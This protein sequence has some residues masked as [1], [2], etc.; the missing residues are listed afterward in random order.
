MLANFVEYWSNPENTPD[1]ITGWNTR[2]FDT[3]YTLARTGYLLDEKTANKY[4]PWNKIERQEIFIRGRKQV[5][6]KI[7]GINELDYLDLFRKFAYTYGNQESYSL[8]HIS[9]VVLGDK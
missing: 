8:N 3:P 1:I 2:L 4:S 7:S 5:A 6:Y 9:H